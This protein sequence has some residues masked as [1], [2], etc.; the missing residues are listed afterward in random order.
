MFEEI[1]VN[2]LSISKRKLVCKVGINDA[3][4]KVSPIIN[5]KRHKCPIYRD[6]AFNVAE[7]L[8]R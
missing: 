3:P 6:L 7:M 2:P 1:S 4:Y 8:F 5:G